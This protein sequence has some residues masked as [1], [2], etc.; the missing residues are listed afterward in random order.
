MKKNYLLVLL[1]L[2]LFSVKAQD[3][4]ASLDSIDKYISHIENNNRDIG[5]LSI[6]KNGKEVYNR[7]FGQK[8]LKN[9]NYDKNTMYRVGSI[10]K[11][12]TALL[13]FKLIE[14]NK[15]NLDDKL[16]KYYPDIPN[17]RKI[18]IGNLLHHTSGLGDFVEAKEDAYWLMKKV[19]NKEI[20]KVIKNTK[21]SFEP[22]EK[23]KYS[24]SGYFLLTRIVEKIYKK[25]YNVILKEVI[26]DKLNVKNFYSD[27][28]NKKNVF[29]SFEYVGEW[30]KKIEFEFSN[31]IGI[32]DIVSTTKSL[33]ILINAIFQYKIINKKSIEAMKSFKWQTS[34]FWKR[35]YGNTYF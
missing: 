32:G 25:P 15:L 21:P 8:K 17:A 22:N 10:S 9:V 18:T 4:K 14:N 20:I 19:S 31:I 26:T 33:N 11:M 6:F 28:D 27:L 5:S 12:F 16:F 24:N 29:D 7:S 2:G 13:A 1:V 35:T 23:T 3:L 30:Q 34:N